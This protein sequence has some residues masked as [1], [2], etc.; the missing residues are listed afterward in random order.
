MLTMTEYAALLR[1]IAPMNPNMRNE[2]LRGVCESLGLDNVQTV[3]SSGNI[4]FETK[5][6][7]ASELEAMLEE[8]WPRELGFQ[9]TTMIRSKR[10][11][12]DL[13][14]L[15]PF[16]DLEHGAETYLLV[17]FSKSPLTVDFELPFEP[18]DRDFSI[19]GATQRELF[20]ITDTTSVRTPDVMAWV[21]NR[22]GKEVTSRT[23]LTVA[24]ILKK[25]DG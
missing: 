6:A 2:K 21:E 12:T 18:P 14:D 23:W 4:V 17:T 10:E 5:A 9:S 16:G 22:F 24:R 25:M 1:G 11:L 15:K 3:I 20:T 19:V 8:A 7:G 13:A